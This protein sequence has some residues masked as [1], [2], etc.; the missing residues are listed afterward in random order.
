MGLY[1]NVVCACEFLGED[2]QGVLQTKDLTS[3]LDLFW[4]APDG[5]LYEV[6]SEWHCDSGEPEQGAPVLRHGRVRPYRKSGV[7]RFT[8]RSGGRY[9]EAL[10]YFKCG[11]LNSILC[12][13]PIFTC[14]TLPSS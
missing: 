7:I 1:S 4:L 10:T 3:L 2:F 13:G 11:E 5:T 6:V 8:A 12:S 14:S 9:L